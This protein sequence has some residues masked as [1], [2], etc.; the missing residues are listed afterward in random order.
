MSAHHIY[1]GSMPFEV[2]CTAIVVDGVVTS[3]VDRVIRPRREARDLI[4]RAWRI[5]KEKAIA[6]Q[7]AKLAATTALVAAQKKKLDAD[8][9]AARNAATEAQRAERAAAPSAARETWRA[10]R[11]ADTEAQRAAQE[12]AAAAKNPRRLGPC[13]PHHQSSASRPWRQIGISWYV[14][15][16]ARIDAAV[17][18]LKSAGL[19]KMSRS[20]LLRLAFDRLDLGIL[21]SNLE[22]AS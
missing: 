18:Q 16:L 7:D 11:T 12:T 15:D 17:D 1:R 6:E 8:R 14:D 5:A 19:T 2:R 3:R 10:A 21:T 13:R 9:A 4:A 20:E 22:R